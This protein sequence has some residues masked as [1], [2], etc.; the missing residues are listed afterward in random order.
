MD[1]FDVARSC[2]RR[3][4]IA[5]P[6]LLITAWYAHNAYSSAKP[7]YYANTV[8]GLAPPSVRQESTS[9]QGE[10]RRNGLLDIGGASLVANLTALGLRDPAV[11][12]QVAAAGGLP[13]Y[14]SKIFPTDAPNPQLPL[15]M[16]EA[17]SPDP[18]AVSKTLELVSAQAEGTLRAI[19]EQA[20]VPEDQM[21]APFVVSPPSIP[22]GGMPT[23]TRSTITIFAAGAGLSIL[24]TVLADLLL[25]RRKSRVQ[26]PPQAGT[27]AA[28]G[29]NPAPSRSDTHEDD[30]S[31]DN[32]DQ[33][34]AYEG[35]LDAR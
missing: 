5:L 20:H 28:A 18:S 19:Q 33:S 10:I 35:P 17:T 15:I 29:P 31:P 16:I 25:P 9:V 11:V 34:P 21:V 26:A 7:V 23:R 1:L 12:S 22:W 3:W 30:A 24:C 6:L 27:E 2:L 14:V 32:K 8:L 4:Y 13:D